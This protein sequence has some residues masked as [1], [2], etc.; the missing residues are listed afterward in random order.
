MWTGLGGR[1]GGI[2]QPQGL[3]GMEEALVMQSPPPQ[4]LIAVAGC[5]QSCQFDPIL[6]TCMYS[7]EATGMARWLVVVSGG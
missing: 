2:G 1:L 5:K 6:Y 4:A 7:W 3:G